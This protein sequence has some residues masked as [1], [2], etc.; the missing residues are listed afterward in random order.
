MCVNCKT[1]FCRNDASSYINLKAPLN[2]KAITVQK[3]AEFGIIVKYVRPGAD[4]GGGRGGQLPTPG[5]P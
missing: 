2:S 5:C 3:Q 1:I 4:F